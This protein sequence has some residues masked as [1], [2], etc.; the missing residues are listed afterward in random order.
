[1]VLGHSYDVITSKDG[2]TRKVKLFLEKTKKTVKC[3]I[4]KLYPVEYFN[5]FTATK[6]RSCNF[7]WYQKKIMQL[8][9]INWCRLMKLLVP[10]IDVSNGGGVLNFPCISD[11][12]FVVMQ[13]ALYKNV[14][15]RK[16]CYYF[17]ISFM[18]SKRKAC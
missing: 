11:L 3:P 10:L 17:S 5:E 15:M 18:V 6:K 7:S 12:A 13:I 1:M 9:F 14:S 8:I 2:A 4:N 16:I